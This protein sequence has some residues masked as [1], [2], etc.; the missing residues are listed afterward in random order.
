ML[1]LLASSPIRAENLGGLMLGPSF[2]FYSGS[3]R[4]RAAHEM[5]G[6]DRRNVLTIEHDRP[7]LGSISRAS[8]R[9]RVATARK[10]ELA[11]APDRIRD[12]SI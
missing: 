10:R 12:P 6:R 8:R 3:R 7:S 2:H 11:K 5:V 1:S 9:T 4:S